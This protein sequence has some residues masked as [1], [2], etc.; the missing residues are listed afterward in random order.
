M[1][2]GKRTQKRRTTTKDDK[3]DDKAAILYTNNKA[4]IEPLFRNHTIK[5]NTS[6]TAKEY[7]FYSK[8]YQR[9][10]GIKIILIGK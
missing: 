4:I 10:Q 2:Q 8:A 6:V 3:I 9:I 7:F 1:G 5:D